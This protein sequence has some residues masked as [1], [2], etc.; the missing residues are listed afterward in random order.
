MDVIW[1][2]YFSLSF[3]S[4]QSILFFV[5]SLCLLI[6][7]YHSIPFLPCLCCL[8]PLLCVFFFYFNLF[9][10]SSCHF[11]IRLLPFFCL[12]PKT[13]IPCIIYTPF[14]CSFLII[15]LILLFP[16]WLSFTLLIRSF[17]FLDHYLS[18]A[19]IHDFAR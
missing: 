18:R 13:F 6:C 2:T 12:L 5:T 19:L 9:F 15:R 3:I 14:L 11:I 8:L 7:E 17:E 4:P 1:L 10:G 16:V